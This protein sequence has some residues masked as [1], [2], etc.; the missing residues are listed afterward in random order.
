MWGLPLRNRIGWLFFL[1]IVIFFH[2]VKFLI[3]P[4]RAVANN[5]ADCVV[6]RSADASGVCSVT[7]D[8]PQIEL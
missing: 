5:T 8:L 2:L 1:T 6:S 7:C 4:L 3:L